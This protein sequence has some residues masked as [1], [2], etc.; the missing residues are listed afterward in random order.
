MG[1][2]KAAAI[3]PV[4]SVQAQEE[5]SQYM[6]LYRSVMW[7]LSVK[8][9]MWDELLARVQAKDETL[10]K[11]GW[12]DED[13][14]EQA[15]RARFE[16]AIDQYQRSVWSHLPQ[17]LRS[18]MSISLLLAF[19]SD[20]RGRISLWNCAVQNGWELPFRDPPTRA[21]IAEEMQLRHEIMEAQKQ[22]DTGALEPPVR[23]I[24]ILI[25][26]KES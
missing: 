9:A 14:N 20:M 17:C 12:R 23:K 8:E 11:F 3:V 16:Y 2:E 18:L 13:Y 7:V 19:S 25:G 10:R 1:G 22:S 15:S 24:R 21:E 5:H 6:H 4:E 26:H